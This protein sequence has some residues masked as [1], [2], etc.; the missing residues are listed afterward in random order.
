MPPLAAGNIPSAQ[1]FCSKVSKEDALRAAEQYKIPEKFGII[2]PFG[3]WKASYPPVGYAAV[4][5]LHFQFGLRFPLFPLVSGVLS[6]YDIALA[7]LAPN[8]MVCSKE[9]VG[10]FTFYPKSKFGEL[11]LNQLV[12]GKNSSNPGWKERFYLVRTDAL[13]LP[14]EW[15]YSR[16]SDPMYDEGLASNSSLLPDVKKLL[17]L[18][19]SLAEITEEAL[20]RV[21]AELC[22]SPSGE[23]SPDL[24]NMTLSQVVALKSAT[25]TATA[26]QQGRSTV[27]SVSEMSSKEKTNAE[28][29]VITSHQQKDSP[30]HLSSTEIQQSKPPA[31]EKNKRSAAADLEY[32]KKK[33]KV[34]TPP[35]DVDAVVNKFIICAEPPSMSC[36]GMESF[37]SL[38]VAGLGRRC[39]TSLPETLR[40]VNELYN[41]ASRA[42]LLEKKLKEVQAEAEQSRRD[43]KD[44]EYQMKL[45]CDCSAADLRCKEEQISVLEKKVRRFQEERGEFMRLYIRKVFQSKGFL[46]FVANLMV[47]AKAWGC[48]SALSDL[49]DI[50]EV[51]SELRSSMDF[52]AEEKFN[53]IFL[54]AIQGDLNLPVVEAVASS[55][56]PMT[57]DELQS[58]TVDHNGSADREPDRVLSVVYP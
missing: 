12:T 51:P 27:A 52:S 56:E 16:K 41:R 58:L 17:G 31:P 37:T 48:H 45:L 3:K 39:F 54:K 10:W 35:Q 40:V 36:A 15:N 50:Q 26:P 5:E 4:Y 22:G 29:I 44:S 24:D 8:A 43:L 7:Q 25:A 38:S 9:F 14:L 11:A 49:A 55:E 34:L 42:E 47:P 23:Y 13:G 21:S 20:D 57:L 46:D 1:E 30:A 2:A 6:H 28:K 33:A 32:P 18:S 19:I 53:Y